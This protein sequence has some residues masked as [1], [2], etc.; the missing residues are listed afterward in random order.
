MKKENINER[1]N[2][3][4]AWIIISVASVMFI[5]F[6]IL[7]VRINPMYSIPMAFLDMLPNTILKII[8]FAFL[9]WA[10]IKVTNKK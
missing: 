6:F 5:R 7:E 3:I 10:I 4:F 8:L 9:V 2:K 1:G